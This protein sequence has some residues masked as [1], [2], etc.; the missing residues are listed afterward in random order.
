MTVSLSATS[1][2]KA[3]LIAIDSFDADTSGVNIGS[4]WAD[5]VPTPEPTALALVALAGAGL[6][7][8]RRLVRH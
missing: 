8:R 2:S 7:R 4:T 3:A 6:L 5:V 1:Q